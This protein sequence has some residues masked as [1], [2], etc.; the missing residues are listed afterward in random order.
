MT[1]LEE[2]QHIALSISLTFDHPQSVKL[3]VKQITLAQKQLRAIK[4]ELNATLRLIN[5]QT[6]QSRADRIFSGGLDIFGERKW[7]GA[8]RVATRRAIARERQTAQQPYLELKEA[9]DNF[10]LEG[11]RLKL[12]AQEYLL[13]HRVKP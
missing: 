7:A 6:S 2:I 4:K 5:H 10:I 13:C 1:T 11:E 3:Q 9:I 8:V 12:M